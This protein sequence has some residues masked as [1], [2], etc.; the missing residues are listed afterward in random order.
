MADAPGQTT[1]AA[2]QRW[3]A[4]FLTH[5]GTRKPSA[6]TIKVYRQDRRIAWIGPGR[7]EDG[8][9]TRDRITR[10]VCGTRLVDQ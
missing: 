7:D 2:D 5:P 1:D 10:A 3:F 6:H 8:A 4:A 9:S